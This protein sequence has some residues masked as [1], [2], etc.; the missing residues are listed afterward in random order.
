VAE[1]SRVLNALRE[2][3]W[4]VTEQTLLDG[5]ISISGQRPGGGGFYFACHESDVMGRLASLVP[6][7]FR[8]L[9]EN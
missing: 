7:A 2:M 8:N 4:I 1:V 5:R 9:A 6:E 3:G